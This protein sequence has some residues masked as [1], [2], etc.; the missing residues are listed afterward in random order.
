MRSTVSQAR[1]SLLRRIQSQDHEAMGL[2]YDALAPLVYTVLLRMLGHTPDAEEALLETFQDV[3]RGA[4]S[5]DPLHGTVDEWVVTM[6]R[7][8]ALQ[9]LQAS[10]QRPMLAASL[11]QVPLPSPA[12]CP[13][14]DGALAASRELSCASIEAL[15]TALAALPVEQRTALELAYYHGW[16]PRDL[17]QHLRQ[18]PAAI[19][20]RLRLGFRQL[21]RALQPYLGVRS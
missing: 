20:T 11:Q 19:R 2:L 1:L 18:S 16:N 10:A 12:S 9:R 5:Y 15:R 17:A 13:P 6:A 7:R 4:M 21:R 3:W 14:P 8:R